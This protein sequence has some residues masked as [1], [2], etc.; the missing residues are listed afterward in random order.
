LTPET[1]ARRAQR[2]ICASETSRHREDGGTGQDIDLAVQTTW[3]CGTT[4]RV[5]RQ[6][7]VNSRLDATIVSEADPD[8]NPPVI[9][10]TRRETSQ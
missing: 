10:A 9:I 8:G 6:G 3:K 7:N 2:T 4:C 1:A 5:Q